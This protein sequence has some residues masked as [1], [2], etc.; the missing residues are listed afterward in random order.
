MLEH[1]SPQE[2]GLAA[3]IAVQSAKIEESG[4]SLQA[5]SGQAFAAL[6]HSLAQ[7]DAPEKELLYDHH[8]L[9]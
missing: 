2:N 3:A 5:Q 7:E 8:K 6:A 1:L 4:S 9:S